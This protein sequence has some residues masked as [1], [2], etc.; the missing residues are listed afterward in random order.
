MGDTPGYERPPEL[1]SVPV[2]WAFETFNHHRRGGDGIA[3]IHPNIRHIMHRHRR[4]VLARR[5]PSSQRIIKEEDTM[6]EGLF[7]LG[8]F[9]LYIETFG[10]LYLHGICTNLPRTAGAPPYPWYLYIYLS[11]IPG[12]D[13]GAK[14]CLGEL[15]NGLV[16][17][18]ELVYTPSAPAGRC[19]TT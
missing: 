14:T 9:L 4:E 18:S 6:K 11:R 3:S 13:Y 10:F 1:K 12:G 7:T 16:F 8:G 19:W 5:Q 17:F 15:G 2:Q